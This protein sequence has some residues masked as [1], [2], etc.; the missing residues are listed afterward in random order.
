VTW[1]ES[2]S[3]FTVP[4][5][6]SISA[7][8]LALLFYFCRSLEPIYKI[9]ER[10]EA[11]KN[12]QLE[13]APGQVLSQLEE[14]EDDRLYLGRN[15]KIVKLKMEATEKKYLFHFECLCKTNSDNWFVLEFNYAPGIKDIEPDNPIYQDV[16]YKKVHPIGNDDA[17]SMLSNNIELYREHFGNPVVA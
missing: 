11:E 5:I 6:L 13:N 8:V 12:K 2:I 3:L 4:A 14:V 9:V 7:I 10:E 15:A 1:Y 17:K 16:N